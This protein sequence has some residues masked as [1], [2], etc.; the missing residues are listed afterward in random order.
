M[1][2]TSSHTDLEYNVQPKTQQPQ[3]LS[4][5]TTGEAVIILP[6]IQRVREFPLKLGALVQF[7]PQPQSHVSHLSK[8]HPHVLLK[9]EGC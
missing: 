7:D 2:A 9:P 3:Q 1:K 4:A 6:S 5:K 8:S